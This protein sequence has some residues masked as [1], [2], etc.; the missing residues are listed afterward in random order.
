[1]SPVTVAPLRDH[2]LS[3]FSSGA[4]E[5]DTWLKSH[6]N[7]A[8][9]RDTARVYVA[10][11]GERSLDTLLSSS[12][13]SHNVTFRGEPHM[14]CQARYLRSYLANLLSTRITRRAALERVCW[15]RRSA[16]HCEYVSLLVH[17]S[18]LSMRGMLR[19]KTG[20]SIWGFILSTMTEASTFV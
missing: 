6:A 8:Q 5:L 16:S 12:A 4:E 14:G 2:D 3:R 15:P 1:V 7:V 18:W 17:G 9:Q 11:D 19:R 20:T 13:S 10:T